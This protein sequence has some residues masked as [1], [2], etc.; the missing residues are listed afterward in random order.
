MNR[1]WIR[2][3]A[4]T[5]TVVLALS[6]LLVQAVAAA[7]PVQAT[8]ETSEG[9]EGRVLL[10]V[11]LVGPAGKP[12][13]NVPVVFES[14]Q[15]F[16]GRST[17]KLGEA[18]TDSA[19]M[20]TQSFLPGFEGPFL[21]RA[22]FAGNESFAPA[23]AEID[24]FTA[25][26][27]AP[28]YSGHASSLLSPVLLKAGMTIILATALIWLFLFSTL[29]K[30]WFGLARRVPEYDKEAVVVGSRKLKRA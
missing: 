26:G 27:A 7:D 18:V 15:D 11:R 22:K 21:L 4:L 10:N 19:G 25:P 24:N 23:A 9:L 1:R 17:M 20:A 14:V 3:A 16:F 5:A 12:V 30:V 28:I 29:A 6:V 8:L 13:N 2:F